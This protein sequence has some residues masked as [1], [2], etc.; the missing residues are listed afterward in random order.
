VLALQCGQVLSCRLYHGGWQSW[1][2]MQRRHVLHGGHRNDASLHTLYCRQVLP[3]GLHYR[4]RNRALQC[5]QVLPCK[6]RYKPRIWG[7]RY[8]FLL[9]VGSNDTSLHTLPCGQVLP[10][11]LHY[12]PRILRCPLGRFLSCRMYHVRVKKLL[13]VPRRS[14]LRIGLLGA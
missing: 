5:G 3:C 4:P 6:I 8:R 10:C 12:K 14:I 1:G 7:L 9:H 2:S 13:A 11:G